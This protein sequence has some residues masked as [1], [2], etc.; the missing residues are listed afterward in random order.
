MLDVNKEQLKKVETEEMRV[1]RAAVGCRMA[2]HY[3]SR[4]ESNRYQYNNKNTIK[5][6]GKN[7]WKECLK[8]PNLFYEYQQKDRKY[9]KRP[10]RG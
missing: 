8:P 7:I 3:Y 6:N 2:D 10:T 1:L 4:S 9:Q 5:I